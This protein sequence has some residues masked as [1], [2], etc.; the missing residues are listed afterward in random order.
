MLHERVLIAGLATK[1]RLPT[2][3]LFTAFP[4]AGGLLAYGPNFPDIMR[5]AGGQVARV[6]RGGRPAEL[7][8]QRPAKFELVV[9]LRTAKLLGLTVPP[10]VLVRADQVIE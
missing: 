3:G 6:L 2:I 9:N 7:P 4:E 5:R 1:H 8:V 10:S